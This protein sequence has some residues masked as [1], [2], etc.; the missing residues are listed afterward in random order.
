MSR[1]N[2]QIGFFF[3]QFLDEESRRV[4]RQP[5]GLSFLFVLFGDPMSAAQ[6]R[7]T[8]FLFRNDP[9]LFPCMRGNFV[10][11]K[12]SSSVRWQGR[13][14][15]HVRRGFPKRNPHRGHRPVVWQE[16]ERSGRSPWWFHEGWRQ[17]RHSVEKAFERREAS[18]TDFS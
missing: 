18:L 7:K 14:P 16:H 6:V 5:D 2:E 17:S 11:S 12:V 1:G 10:W 3:V 4:L 9:K 8:I 13:F 15:H